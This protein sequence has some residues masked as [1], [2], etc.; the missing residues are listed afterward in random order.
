LNLNENSLKKF[1]EIYNNIQKHYNKKSQHNFSSSQ[2][3]DQEDILKSLLK[4]SF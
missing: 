3:E 2:V 1:D 4:G